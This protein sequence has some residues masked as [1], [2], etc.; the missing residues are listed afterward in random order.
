[1]YF[2]W[3]KAEEFSTAQHLSG[4][5]IITVNEVDARLTFNIDDHLVQ[6]RY[7]PVTTFGFSKA[8]SFRVFDSC[9]V[10]FESYTTTP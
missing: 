4:K 6:I 7:V 3:N 2:R 10:E 9:Q 1:M 8:V 5:V